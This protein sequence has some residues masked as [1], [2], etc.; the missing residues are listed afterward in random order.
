MAP[1][2]WV[3]WI[4]IGYR[5][6]EPSLYFD[7]RVRCISGKYPFRPHRSVQIWRV[8]Q[9]QIPGQPYCEEIS[10]KRSSNL[11]ANEAGCQLFPF[12]LISPIFGPICDSFLAAAAS[13]IH[14]RHLELLA[15]SSSSATHGKTS[16]RR[17]APRFA[18]RRPFLCVRQKEGERERERDR[19]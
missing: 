9:R 18:G 5:I 13:W 14:P 17:F 16:E 2:V 10:P 12:L 3:A 7:W 6:T 1:L 8:Q 15:P 4:W 19:A 11:G